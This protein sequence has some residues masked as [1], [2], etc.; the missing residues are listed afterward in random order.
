VQRAIPILSVLGD[1]VTHVGPVCTGQVANAANQVIVGLTIVAVAE[2]FA[3]ASRAG[4]DLLKTREALQVGFAD[5]RILRDHGFRMIQENYAPGATI[6]VQRKDMKQ[7]LALAKSLGLELPMTTLAA[8]YF[9]TA[10]D[11]GFDDLDQ[12]AVFSSWDLPIPNGGLLLG[13]N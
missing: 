6:A 7:A 10:A 1:R 9:D 13:A 5:S 12:S 4:V 11:R 2:A 8:G 3:L